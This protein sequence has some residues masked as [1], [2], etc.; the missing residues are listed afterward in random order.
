MHVIVY[1][2]I[3]CFHIRNEKSGIPD[4]YRNNCIR[5]MK[6]MMKLPCSGVFYQ[7]PNIFRF[8]LQKLVFLAQTNC[9]FSLSREILIKT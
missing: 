2:I 3:H 4:K 8:L 1:L 9:Y 7:Q 6:S 5:I